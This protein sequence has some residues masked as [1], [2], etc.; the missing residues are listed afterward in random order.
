M[1]PQT[2]SK[3]GQIRQPTAELAALERLKNPHRPIMVRRCF[4]FFSAVYDLILLI[5]ASN[6]DIHK[7]FDKFEFCQDLKTDCRVS[8][9]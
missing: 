7:S 4:H 1:K 3:F 2:S 9:H 8:C 6:E 5:L